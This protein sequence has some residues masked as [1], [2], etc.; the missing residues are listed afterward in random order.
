MRDV[1]RWGELATGCRAGEGG[2]GDGD[3]GVV[4][5]RM[6]AALQASL[7]H[8]AQLIFIQRFRSVSDRAEATALLR[9]HG[10]GVGAEQL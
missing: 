1:L 6:E 5:G 2:A 3:A 8:S 4:S 10:P 9:E 7:L